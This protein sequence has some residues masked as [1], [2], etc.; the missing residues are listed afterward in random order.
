MPMID[1]KIEE[2]FETIMTSQEYQEYQKIL[3]IINKDKKLSSLI[4]EIKKLNKQATILEY[5]GNPKY[6]EIDKKIKQKT[7]ILNN[8][9]LYNEYKNKMNTLNDILATS[10][11]IIQKYIDEIV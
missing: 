3:N 1:N 8:N 10:S 5:N 6:K 7:I 2:L 11:N 4:K 9:P